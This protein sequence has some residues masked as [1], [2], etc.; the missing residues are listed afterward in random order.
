[1]SQ[2]TPPPPQT[3]RAKETLSV[4]H[5]T[6][7]HTEIP[8]ESLL[9]SRNESDIAGNCLYPDDL[10]SDATP[11][12]NSNHGGFLRI[13]FS[14]KGAPQLL[15]LGLLMSLATGPIVVLV[16]DIMEDRYARLLYQYD[17][18]PCSTF[19][20]DNKPRA[21]LMG[22]DNGLNA[23]SKSSAAQSLLT[24][25][26]SPMIGSTSDCR[27][28]RGEMQSALPFS[29]C[30]GLH[31][32]QIN[33]VLPVIHPLIGFLAFGFF[34]FL[35]APLSL[36]MVQCIDTVNPIWYYISF[37]LSGLCNTFILSFSMLSDIIPPPF[38][39][40]SYALYLSSYSF[41]FALAQILSVLLSRLAVTSLSLALLSSGLLFVLVAMP[42]TL[43]E[44]ASN[45]ALAKRR[46]EG[47]SWFKLISRPLKEMS[48][49]NRDYVFLTLS[50]IAFTTGMVYNADHT[51]IVYY[52]E[53]EL[54]I[55]YKDM[56][57]MFFVMS[58]LGMFMKVYVLKALIH[59]FGEKNILVT[60]C[61][62]GIVHNFLYG[63]ATSKFIVTVALC[64]SELTLLVFPVQIAMRSNRAGEDEQGRVQGAFSSLGAIA[65]GIG[66]LS[67]QFIYHR[68][69]HNKYPGAGSMWFFAAVVYSV[70]AIFSVALPL[71]NQIVEVGEG[72]LT[73]GEETDAKEPLL[74]SP[75][76]Y[77]EEA[78]P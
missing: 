2:T 36:L 22:G 59:W 37:S 55:S 67:L 63:I 78:D 46:A 70:G 53:N 27:G 26:A 13:F 39:A 17:G 25:I 32:P 30:S 64:L 35:L 29:T 41:G 69:E 48:I 61:V 57:F 72:G 52:V 62:C 60:T 50:V 44:E 51:L 76:G 4:I 15:L 9:Q 77:G 21:C 24:L 68:T 23:A 38:R 33:L 12:T 47:G 71:E 74:Q 31:H 42:E 19:D 10:R 6:E 65:S 14:A 58:I 43:S 8:I 28:R 18:M 66:P 49:L 5:E 40:L 75:K 34:L 3:Q 1:M 56:A 54:A 16:P 20:R 73:L 45:K 7:T 11:Q